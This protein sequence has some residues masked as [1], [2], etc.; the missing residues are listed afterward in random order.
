MVKAELRCMCC[1]HYT[2][3]VK[4]DAEAKELVDQVNR[5]E[6][7]SLPGDHPYVAAAVAAAIEAPDPEFPTAPPNCTTVPAPPPVPTTEPATPSTPT[8]VPPPPPVPTSNP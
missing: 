1:T 6:L 7:P 2:R 3:R 5:L 8:D 4:D